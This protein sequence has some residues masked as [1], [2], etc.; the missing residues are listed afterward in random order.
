MTRPLAD[1]VRA[2]RRGRRSDVKLLVDALDGGAFYLPVARAEP[3]AA[4]VLVNHA[5]RR[6]CPL[7]TSRLSL[8]DAAARAGWGAPEIMALDARAALELARALLGD[9]LRGVVIDPFDQHFLE[10]DADELEALIARQPI[11]FERLLAGQPVPLDE[12]ILVS[13]PPEPQP[14]LESALNVLLAAHPRVVSWRLHQTFNP[15]RERK[16]RL[17]IAL[18]TADGRGDPALAER[19]LAAVD[20]LVPGERVQVIFDAELGA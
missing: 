5:G 8:H 17:T 15:E 4:H 3:F 16:P 11:P 2:A 12:P 18:R 1:V 10:L 13:Q 19:V 9:D 7:F 14:A 20:G 6:F